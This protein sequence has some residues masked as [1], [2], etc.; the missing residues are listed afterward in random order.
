MVEMEQFNVAPAER[1]RPL[2]AGSIMGDV[3]CA[4]VQTCCFQERS[5]LAC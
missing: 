2:N 3:E 1:V 5:E 4:S